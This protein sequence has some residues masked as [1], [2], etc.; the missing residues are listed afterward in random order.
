MK[1]V[2]PT[3]TIRAMLDETGSSTYALS[4]LMGKSP[5]W[6][7]NSIGHSARVDT[8]AKMADVLGLQV[9]ILGK[10]GHVVAVIEPEPEPDDAG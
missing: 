1:T 2:A 8:L 6:A 3:E 9:A 10:D 7:W 4:K 5:K